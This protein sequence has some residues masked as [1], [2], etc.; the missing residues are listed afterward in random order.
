MPRPALNPALRRLGALVGE[1]DME[2]S[3][4]GRVVAYGRTSF[5]W[6]AG[7][8]FVIQHADAEPAESA[9]QD[10]AAHSPFPVTT[11]V[12]LDDTSQ[13]FSMLYADA[14]GVFR[15]YQM[16]LADDVWTMWRNAPGFHQRFIGTFVDAGN[17]IEARWDRSGDGSSW[18]LDFY[19]TYTRVS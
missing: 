18:E 9:P 14:R 17:T 10:W 2:A 13:N 7:E 5:D 4:G 3:V 16:T 8:P 1:W 19:V 12:G 15:V 6:L 11:I